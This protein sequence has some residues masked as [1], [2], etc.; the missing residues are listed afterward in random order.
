MSRVPSR[1]A[2]AAPA[3]EAPQSRDE[4]TRW[5]RELGEAE[6]AVAVLE[7]HMN[8]VIAAAKSAFDGAARP[9]TARAAA[10]RAGIEAWAAANRAQLTLGLARKTVTLATGTITWRRL[11][12]RIAVTGVAKVIARLEAAG[13]GRFL[14]CK[15][16][17]DKEAML[18]EPGAA[19]AIE[20]IAVVTDE[21][22]IDIAPDTA[23]LGNER[24]P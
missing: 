15:T 9:Q 22:R 21:E 11:P 2:P 18:K 23:T 4:A 13:L 17:L 1:I 19:A 8:D 16:E 12:P 3:L 5:L 20:G 6:R 7:A 10:L 24:K 14:R